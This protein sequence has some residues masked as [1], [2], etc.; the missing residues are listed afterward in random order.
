MKIQSVEFVASAVDIA[1]YPKPVLPKICF[2]GRSN[3]GKSSLINT[4]VARKNLARTSSKPGKTQTVN[5]YRVNDG[6][7]LVD[8]P[9]YGYAKVPQ[10]VH[11][12]MQGRI[13]RFLDHMD[14]LKGIIQLIDARHPP[15]KLDVTIG[16]WIKTLPAVSAWALVK[17]DKVSHSKRALAIRELQTALELLSD[18]PIIPFSSIDGTGKKELLTIVSGMLNRKVD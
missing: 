2:L 8:L 7:D 15:M 11:H 18:S 14:N 17:I 13:G 10:S 12:D 5:F 4:L 9:G 16:L 6:F 1:H 3:V